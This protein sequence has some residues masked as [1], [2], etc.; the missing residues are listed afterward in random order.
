M[1]ELWINHENTQISTTEVL[2][3][4]PWTRYTS[5][6]RS[7]EEALKELLSEAPEVWVNGDSTRYSTVEVEG[8][9]KSS[10]L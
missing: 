10:D 7:P 9:V 2:D 4:D 5:E 6:E 8:F 1:T 3:R